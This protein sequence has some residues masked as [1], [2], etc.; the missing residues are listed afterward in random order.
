VLHL[1]PSASAVWTLLDGTQPLAGVAAELAGMFQTPVDVIR[2]EVEA[3]VA[4]FDSR[5]L[6]VRD[7]PPEGPA[8]PSPL[9][10][11]SVFPRP[12]EPPTRATQFRG[13]KGQVNLR[14]GDHVIGVEYDSARTA[15]ALRAKAGVLLTT[16]SDLQDLAEVPRAFGVRTTRG[17]RGVVYHGT[18][19][20]FRRDSLDEAV[21]ALLEAL[22][23]LVTR[24]PTD[25]VTPFQVYA[26][27][28][29]AVL[30]D[31]MSAEVDHEQLGRAGIAEV[32]SCAPSVDPATGDVRAGGNTYRLAGIVEQWVA[33]DAPL[34]DVRRTVTSRVVGDRYAFALV[35]DALGER[36]T[37]ASS[38]RG[39]T[40]VTG[41][42]ARLLA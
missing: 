5:G 19:V 10:G 8:E 7:D 23:D 20:R 3:A 9:V 24:R 29:A 4:D 32:P 6:L 14:A 27:D 18:D 30:V 35:V 26:R 15:R 22:N 38:A 1:N 39:E 33:L 12:P 34:D 28:R 16:A 37:T 21:A 31:T 17:R 25:V 41:A 42:V 11:L 40:D 13:W 2:P 36:V